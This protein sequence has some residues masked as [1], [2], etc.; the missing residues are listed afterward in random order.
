[1]NGRISSALITTAIIVIA[2]AFI[3]LPVVTLVLFSVHDGRVPVPPFHGPTL[4]WYG[5]ILGNARV[6]S[7][8]GSSIVVGLVSS[9]ISVALA[10]LAGWGLS[11]HRVPG[12]KLV[13]ALLLMPLAVSYL[14]VGIG[15]MVSFSDYV[16]KS[17]GFVVIGHVVLNLPL[18]FAILYVQFDTAQARLE[19]AAR[20]LGAS[21]MQVF[22]RVTL[23]SLKIPIIAAFALCFTFSWDEFIVAF[24]LSGFDPTLPVVIWG[25]LRTGLDPQTNAAG[26]LVFLVSICFALFVELFLFRKKPND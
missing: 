15:L 26:T 21:E 12:R 18:A 23:P 16:P 20:D 1:M 4:E 14:I 13:E 2:L 6:M 19:A 17:I 22:F 5:R 8:T 3:Y 25:L 24:L 11:R 10:L 9:V 7:A